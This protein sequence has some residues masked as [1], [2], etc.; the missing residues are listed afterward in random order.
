[1]SSHPTFGYL[2]NAIPTA[3]K[4]NTLLFWLVQMNPNPEARIIV[5]HKNPYPTKLGL[6]LLQQAHLISHLL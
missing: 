3:T 6:L 1:M 2:A 4:D 5:S